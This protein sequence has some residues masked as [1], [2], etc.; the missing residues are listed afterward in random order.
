MERQFRQLDDATKLRISQKLRGRSMCDTHKQAISNSMKAYWDT[1]P[2]KP[3]E[4]NNESKNQSTDEK[5]M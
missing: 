5:D 1:I 3:T 4:N 2:N